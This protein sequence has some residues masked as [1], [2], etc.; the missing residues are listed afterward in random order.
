MK[1]LRNLIR[2]YRIWK[3]KRKTLKLIKNSKIPIAVKNQVLSTIMTRITKQNWDVSLNYDGSIE[4]RR[5][6]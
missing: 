3:I 1:N 5:E 4:A 6:S 2:R